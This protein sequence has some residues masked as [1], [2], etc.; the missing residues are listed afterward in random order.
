ME[1]PCCEHPEAYFEPMHST[2]RRN[3]SQVLKLTFLIQPPTHKIRELP[4]C[5]G[6][7]HTGINMGMHIKLA[8]VHACWGWGKH[9]MRA[10]DHVMS[11]RLSHHAKKNMQCH[12]PCP[13]S[14]NKGPRHQQMPQT[15]RPDCLM[16]Q[17]ERQV[18]RI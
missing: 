5:P 15:I 1:V 8:F 12:M 18:C 11:M 10:D 14:E 3:S 6:M 16:K 9:C 7:E 2:S 17:P 13:V 4:V